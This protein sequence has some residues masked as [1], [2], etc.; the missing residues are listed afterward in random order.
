MSV[1]QHGLMLVLICLLAACATP[2]GEGGAPGPVWSPGTDIEQFWAAYAESRGGLT[3]GSTEAVAG[4]EADTER[5]TIEPAKRR[6][7]MILTATLI[8]LVGAIMVIFSS[9]FFP[10]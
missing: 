5:I 8:A 6:Q 10:A 2:G 4:G 3:F 1:L 9:L 7:D